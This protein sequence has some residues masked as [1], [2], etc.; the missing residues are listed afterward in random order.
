MAL[1]SGLLSESTWALDVLA[2]LLRDDVTVAWFGLQ[3]LPGLVEVLLEHLRRC[4]IELFPGDFDDL[5]VVFDA[6]AWSTRDA[7]D[8]KTDCGQEGLPLSCPSKSAIGSQLVHIEASSPDEDLVSDD[9]RWDIYGDVDSS[10]LDWQMGRGDHTTHIQTHFNHLG[11]LDFATDRFFSQNGRPKL[12]TDHALKK[13]E[14]YG[15]VLSQKSEHSISSPVEKIREKDSSCSGRD[16]PGSTKEQSCIGSRAQTG[17]ASET[18]SS[19]VAEKT[20]DGRSKLSTDL[21]S[22]KI[23]EVGRGLSQKSEHS[24]SS[25][26]EKIGEKSSSCSSGDVPGSTVEQTCIESRA[27]TGVAS[28]MESPKVVQKIAEQFSMDSLGSV[29]EKT[30]IRS[31][32]GSCRS[33]SGEETGV[34]FKADCPKVVKKIAEQFS[35]DSGVESVDS[36]KYKTCAGPGAQTVLSSETLRPLASG[37][38]H[39]ICHSIQTS[40]EDVDNSDQKWLRLKLKRLWSDEWERHDDLDEDGN[41]PV[42]SV[43]GD[44]EQDTSSRCLA[45]SNIIRGL[46][47]IPGNGTELA[48]HPGVVATLSRLLLYHHQHTGPGTQSADDVLDT[49]PGF[50]VVEVLREDALVTFAN[51]AGQLE[52]ASYPEEI[53]VPL[54]DGLLH[55][56]SCRA[57]CAVDPLPSA[58]YHRDL[59]SPQR[60][61]LEGLCKLCVTD[62]N[63][64][65][66]LATP[67]F[68][69]VVSILGNLVGAMA[70]PDCDQVWREFAIVFASSLVAGDPG[71][72]RA[73]AL[74]R[75]AVPVLVGFVEAAAVDSA[76]SAGGTSADMVRRATAV[77]RAVA[78]LPEGRSY[79]AR[80]Y[81][82]RLLQLAVAPSLDSTV[83]KTFAHILH[84]CSEL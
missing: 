47:F 13:I 75:S 48:R 79:L 45:L 76:P 46:S 27:K 41:L 50:E 36:V 61:A 38:K 10:L 33:T 26:V 66:L 22:E 82:F 56:A 1:K 62:A 31:T 52:L 70:N 40:E 83:L 74:H 72:A 23:Q 77:L 80:N 15:T 8:W 37:C 53:C 78:E 18:T 32:A 16:A 64:D 11:S 28:E 2:V 63:V 24:T 21:A 7:K 20:E 44:D 68:D 43:V 12:S 29:D 25:P 42:L 30:C 51:I 17:V 35:M 67:P 55:W 57:P 39:G 6:S 54:L 9:K 5:E 4:L 60:L 65:L 19:R 14:D 34:P 3:H 69:R 73:L 71:V 49:R 58:I 84:M 81:Q 59:V